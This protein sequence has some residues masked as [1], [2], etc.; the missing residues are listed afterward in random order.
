VGSDQTFV[1]W[2]GVVPYLSLAAIEAT[3]RDLP[4]CSLAVSYGVPEDTWPASVRAV[5]HTFRA[6]A[7]EAGEAPVSRFTPERFATILADHRFTVVEDVGSEDVE[8]SYGLPALSIGAERIVLATK[9][10]SASNVQEVEFAEVLE[11]EED[12]VSSVSGVGAALRQSSM[13]RRR[14]TGAR[15]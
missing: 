2:L 6:M 15:H 10:P 13:S 12:A 5:S 4:P 1:S 7:V 11:R 3:L 9:R 14:G 8:A